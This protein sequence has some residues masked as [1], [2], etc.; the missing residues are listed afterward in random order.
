MP[1]GAIAMVLVMLDP[2]QTEMASRL[3]LG[4]TICADVVPTVVLVAIGEMIVTC[5]FARRRNDPTS[6]AV[7]AT[8]ATIRPAAISRL[9][10]DILISPLRFHESVGARRALGSLHQPHHPAMT[11]ALRHYDAVIRRTAPARRGGAAARV[12]ATLSWP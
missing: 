11:Y 3:G 8:P 5:A 12:R 10:R 7:A 4:P 6:A 1:S 2:L 9:P